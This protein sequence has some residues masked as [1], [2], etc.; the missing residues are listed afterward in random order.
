MADLVCGRA[1][2]N[3]TD[4]TVAVGRHG[5]QVNILFAGQFNNL[6]G[7]FAKSEDGLTGKAIID[8]MALSFFEVGAILF[9]FFAFRQ[10]QLIKI[11]RHPAVGNMDQQKLRAGQSG[12]RL[13]VT[14][15][16]VVGSAIFKWDQNMLIHV[17][18]DECRMRNDEV[19]NRQVYG[20][21]FWTFLDRLSFGL[22]RHRQ[23]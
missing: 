3:I 7:G 20:A 21:Y 23:T 15:N 10:F 22:L 2:K 14:E 18:N 19:G 4:E 13:D 12:K 6:V 8:Q 9:H 5:Y 17:K 16:G 11:S 1:I